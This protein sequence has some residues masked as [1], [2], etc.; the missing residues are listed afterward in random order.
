MNQRTCNDEFDPNRPGGAWAGV[1]AVRNA[2]APA[3]GAAY[4]LST[5]AKCRLRTGLTV[6]CSG[7]KRG[8]VPRGGF[9]MGNVFITRQSTVGRRLLRHETKHSDQW[10][11]LGLGFPGLYAAAEAAAWASGARGRRAG[12]NNVFER[13]AGRADGG[14]RC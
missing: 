10:A 8:A 9:M 4:A 2:P 13:A 3:V 5:G 1:R 6:V 7:A 11:V 12:C 14:Y